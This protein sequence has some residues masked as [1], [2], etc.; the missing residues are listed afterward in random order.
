MN[1]AGPTLRFKHNRRFITK[2]A[3]CVGSLHWEGERV[4]RWK[5]SSNFSEDYLARVD[6]DLNT[7]DQLRFEL[8]SEDEH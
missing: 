8:V 5:I 6:L 4:L 3:D 2:D 1:L 7:A